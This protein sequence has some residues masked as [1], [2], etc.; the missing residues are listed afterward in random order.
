MSPIFPKSAIA[1]LA[2]IF[3]FRMLGLFMILPI[4]TPYAQHLDHATPFL[5]GLALGIYGFTQACLQ[6]PF[7]F[8]SDRFG[9][10]TLIT[11]G[12]LIFALGSLIAAMSDSIIGIIIGRALQGTGAVGS[13]II[14]LVADLT[15][16]E[17][18]TKAMAMIG[19]TIGLSFLIAMV[20]G[21]FLNQFI[22]IPGIFTLTALLAIVGII[23]LHWKVPTPHSTHAQRD[24]EP[25]PTL[26][27]ALLRNSELLRLD[28]GIFTLH[29]TL[30]A[31]F[32]VV[33]MLLEHHLGLAQKHLWLLYLPVLIWAFIAMFPFIIIA[34]KQRKMKPVFVS[35]IIV[36]ILSILSLLFFE[37]S[38]WMIGL[39]LWLFFTAFTL[40]EASLP[41]LISKIAP[42]GSKGTAMGIYSSSQF[43][44]IFFGGTIGGWLYS[45]H[46]TNGV[47]WFCL[48]LLVIWLIAA[49]TMKK[50]SHLAT[51]SL[52]IG[53]MD[54][55]QA[56]QLQQVLIQQAGVADVL[57]SLDE[58]T[59]YLKID[60]QRTNIDQLKQIIK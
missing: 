5:I 32:I 21:S 28:W 3:A 54:I 58:Q 19:M 51:F 43:L 22:G 7:G 55:Q 53:T 37:Q 47:L 18:R 35:A 10:K 27:K 12:L 2:T 39:T 42:A 15:I 30:T 1:S 36:L 34:E 11:I 52:N 29:A 13:V 56:K 48:I 4:F 31:S 20:L 25:V 26:F 33:P 50:P 46:Q 24:A 40:L 17:H 41:S 57:I 49:S 60:R 9:R 14:A 38:I 45:Q 6:I 23:L 44:G 59:A 16:E 8:L